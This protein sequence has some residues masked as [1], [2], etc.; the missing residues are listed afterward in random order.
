MEEN[1][2]RGGENCNLK[3]SEALNKLGQQIKDAQVKFM[4]P[5]RHI[6]LPA[7]RI[8]GLPLHTKQLIGH[9]GYS[10]S[11]RHAQIVGRSAA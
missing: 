1:E 7:R 3:T 8:G 6:V 5:V 4:E 9:G 10:I 2:I 11:E